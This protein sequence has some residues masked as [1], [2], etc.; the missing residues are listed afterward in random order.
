MVRFV[1]H[2]RLHGVLGDLEPI[3]TLGHLDGRHRRQTILGIRIQLKTTVLQS[4]V[5]PLGA[6]LMASDQCR[7]AFFA[8]HGDRFP[9]AVQQGGGDGVVVA[10]RW[11]RIIRM[12]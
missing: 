9:E 6:V 7:Q 5:Q 8:G 3:H 10:V 2:S 11:S 4:A 1:Q 12:L